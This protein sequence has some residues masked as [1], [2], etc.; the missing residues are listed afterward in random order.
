VPAPSIT[1][2]IPRSGRGFC[3]GIYF[4]FWFVTQV[5]SAPG[6]AAHEI[7]KSQVRPEAFLQPAQPFVETDNEVVEISTAPIDASIFDV[8]RD[9]NS[10]SLPDL[11]KAMRPA[12]SIPRP[13]A[14]MPPPPS[15]PGTP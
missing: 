10:T 7:K 13:N 6:A 14:T 2:V 5:P 9:Y 1:A 3:G 15:L 4:Y 8:P 12:P 11:L